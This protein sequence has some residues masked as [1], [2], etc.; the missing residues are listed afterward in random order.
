MRVVIAAPAYYPAHKAGGPVPGI[1]GVVE[2]LAGHEVHVVTSD[3]DLGESAPYPAPYRDT[4]QVGAASV[5]Y[6]PPPGR[7]TAG[8]WWRALRLL[9]S[10]DVVQFNSLMSKTHTI[11]PLLFLALTRFRGQVVISPRGELASSAL[12]LGGSRQKRLWL[13]LL[14]RAGWWRRVGRSSNGGRDANVLWVVSS[15]HEGDDVRRAFPGAAV[16]VAPERLRGAGSRARGARPPLAEGLRM[17]SVGRIAPVKGTVDLVRGLAAVRR[18]VHLR[19]LGLVEDADYAAQVEDAIAALPEHVTVELAGALPPD[20]VE[21]ELGGAHLFALLTRGEN[22]G[23]ALG[24]ALRAGCPVLVTDT[25]PWTPV[26][27]AGAGVVLTVPDCASV[28]RVA[29]AVD[30]FAEMD[31]RTHALWS[32]RARE[33]VAGLTQPPSLVELLE[34]HP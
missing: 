4:V 13:G 22:F 26:G 12:V 34:Q 18:P 25:T 24:E 28:E 10:A 23:H 8:T 30:S 6:L 19:L 33:Y 2:G 5:T 3:R 17:V 14:A 27:E 29:E 11:V 7:G 15:D 32:E 9:H 31:D 1:M 21:A 16:A 20:E